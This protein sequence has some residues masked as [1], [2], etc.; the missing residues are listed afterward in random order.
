M[1]H[2]PSLQVPNFALGC[3]DI[4]LAAGSAIKN[5]SSCLILQWFTPPHR[6][7]RDA[8]PHGKVVHQHCGPGKGK[9]K[10]PP[11]FLLDVVYGATAV[12]WWGNE[13]FRRTIQNLAD[14]IYYK[15]ESEEDDGDGGDGDEGEDEYE[16]EDGAD[17]DGEGDHEGADEDEDGADEGG[18][19]EDE[20]SR[21]DFRPRGPLNSAGPSTGRARG[22]TTVGGTFQAADMVTRPGPLRARRGSNSENATG[23]VGKTTRMNKGRATQV[24][25]VGRGKVLAWLESIETNC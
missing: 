11:A 16:G 23:V 24:T 6:A 12:N 20:G 25:K 19:G 1:C 15:E 10:L 22:H 2:L 17:E 5:G 3:K 14:E 7:I 4:P 18:G 13:G 21:Y 8:R 9:G